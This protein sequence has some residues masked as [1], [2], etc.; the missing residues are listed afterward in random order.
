MK[1]GTRSG[2]VTGKKSI[3]DEK[4][5]RHQYV[6]AQKELV[7][8]ARERLGGVPGG[9]VGPVPGGGDGKQGLVCRGKLF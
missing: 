2:G 5:V 1:R 4:V 9:I 7:P 3:L 8:S 6:G